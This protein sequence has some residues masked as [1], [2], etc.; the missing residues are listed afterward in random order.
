M[1]NENIIPFRSSMVASERS[2][3]FSDKGAGQRS[4]RSQTSFK[5]LFF[6]L[7]YNEKLKNLIDDRSEECIQ[8]KFQAV[9]LFPYRETAINNSRKVELSNFTHGPVVLILSFRTYNKF[10]IRPFTL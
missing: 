1:E 8:K 4:D 2:L 3:F 10:G 7:L 6:Y 5:T 9:N